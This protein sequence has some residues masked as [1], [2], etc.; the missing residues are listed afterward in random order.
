MQDQKM[1]PS[2]QKEASMLQPHP[3]IIR[4]AANALADRNIPL[5]EYRQQIEW[6]CGYPSVLAVQYAVFYSGSLDLGLS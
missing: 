5:M 2:A 3:P 4:T 1:S 6:R